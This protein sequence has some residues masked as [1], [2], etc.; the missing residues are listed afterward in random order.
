VPID[1]VGFDFQMMPKSEYS[2]KPGDGVYTYV[3]F[4]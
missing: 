2:N 1:Q 4:V 3:R